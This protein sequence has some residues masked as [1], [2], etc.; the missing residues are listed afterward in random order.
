M[1][2]NTPRPAPW[3]VLIIAL[4]WVPAA[5]AEEDVLRKEM[6]AKASSF[7]KRGLWA[8]ACRAFD[9][10]SRKYRGHS[11]YR[12]AYHYCLRRLHL[13][14][15]QADGDYR[16]ALSR[17]STAQALDVYA[18]VIGVLSSAHPDRERASINAL[19]QSGIDELYNALDDPAFRRNHFPDADEGA[20]ST[21]RARLKT[22]P[23]TSVTT[24]AEAREQARAIA[25]AAARDGL[26][27]RGAASA[28]LILEFAAGACNALDE[29]SLFVTP[30]QLG[31]LQAA[32]RGKLV[33][34]GLEM[35]NPDG[36]LIINRITAG[37]PAAAKG[38]RQGDLVLKIAGAPVEDLPPEN[39]AEKL[40]GDPG[41][42]V[43][44]TVFRA[45]ETLEVD[46]IRRV[47]PLPSVEELDPHQL[48]TGEIVRHLR[49]NYFSEKTADL[50]KDHLASATM[51]GDLKGLILDLRGN[52]GGLFDS[53]IAVAELF[54]PEGVI[55][56]GTSPLK[57]YHRTYK[58]ETPGLYQSLPLAVLIDGDTASAAEVLAGAI[59][60][61]RGQAKG[62]VLVGQ[63]SYGKGSI[64]CLIPLNTTALDKAAL[65]LTVAKL[66]SP[67]S[68]PYTGRGVTPDRSVLDT[69]PQASLKAG[70]EELH[71]IVKRAMGMMPPAVSPSPM[72]PT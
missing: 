64:Q 2:R 12:T 66:F 24:R 7:E 47:A 59:K 43:K 16:A 29:H 44:V 63:T 39:A 69:D 57:K 45:G 10:L 62:A 56:V 19:F 11:G 49:I 4:L 55:V 38:L 13:V 50:V 61:T 15:R 28:A 68:L 32:L 70:L 9:D 52:P 40:R 46:L 67:G 22:W 30:G 3:L 33:S 42:A 34:V 17:L 27:M 8:E 37:G 31:L 5:R 71:G 1:K 36:K 25:V 23:M 6:E 20:L 58:V 14:V 51:T 72:P 35:S 60:D 21:F 41:T 54:L 18:Q 53:A 48:P 65:K 26:T